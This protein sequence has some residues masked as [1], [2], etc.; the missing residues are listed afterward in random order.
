MKTNTLLL[1]ERNPIPPTLVSK[2]VFD[3]IETMRKMIN[4]LKEKGV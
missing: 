4:D 2:D 3:M 1:C